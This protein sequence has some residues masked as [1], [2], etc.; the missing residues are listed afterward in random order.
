MK[1]YS[2]FGV[3]KTLKSCSTLPVSRSTQTAQREVPSAGA[4]VSQTWLP[5]TTGDDQPLSWM[6]VFQVMLVF[7]SQWA[8]RPVAVEMPAPWGPRNWG[9][10]S[11]EAMA[12]QSNK[13]GRQSSSLMASLGVAPV[14]G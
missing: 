13:A 10:L 3:S 5:Q 8:G 7:S 6:A 1:V 14:R 9:Q 2:F 4:V 11:A 12:G